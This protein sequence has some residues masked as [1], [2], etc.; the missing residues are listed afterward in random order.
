[1][2]TSPQVDNISLFAAGFVVA[3]EDVQLR[4]VGRVLYAA[5]LAQGHEGV[6]AKHLASTYRPGRRSPEWRKIKPRGGTNRPK[7]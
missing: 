3:A 5:A 7:G 1:M 6:V 2:D 4:I